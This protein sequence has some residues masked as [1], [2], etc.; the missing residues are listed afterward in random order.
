MEKG[1]PLPELPLDPPA[2]RTPPDPRA[3]LIDGLVWAALGFGAMVALLLIGQMQMPDVPT[4]PP[5]PLPLRM[6]WPLPLPILFLG[7][8]LMLYYAL[9]S[10][11]A[12]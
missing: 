7:I 11:R 4:R 6:L 3:P 9:V 5:L 2:V 8:G 12:R 1:I 10:R